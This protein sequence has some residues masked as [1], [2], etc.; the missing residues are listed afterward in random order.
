MQP[1]RIT[2][3]I[4]NPFVAYDNFSPSLDALLEW[5][6][7]EERGLITPNPTPDSLVQADLPLLKGDIQG[8]WYWTVSSPHYIL[9]EQQ[10]TKYRRRWDQ[11]DKHLNW[12]GKRAKFSTS[13][14]HTKSYDLPL[15]LRSTPQ[16]DWFAVGDGDEILRLLEPCK[17]L[18][19]KRAYGFGEIIRWEVQQVEQDW[20]LWGPQ[21]QLMRPMPSRL[22][23]FDHVFDWA[24]LRWGWRPPGRLTCNQELCACPVHNVRSRAIAV[25]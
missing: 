11:Q 22:L 18:G 9:E 5:Y 12:G 4:A 21:G 10:I 20:H 16:I 23:T 2:A 14:G 3:K 25:C 8:E 17:S 13:E 15:Y 19:K 7:L 6:W 1:L 24:P